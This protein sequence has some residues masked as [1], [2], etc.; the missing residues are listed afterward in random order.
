MKKILAL[1]VLLMFFWTLGAQPIDNKIIKDQIATFKKEPKG[2]YQQIMWYCPDGS[3]VPPKQRCPEK[4]GVQR[5]TYNSWIENLAKSNHIYLGQILSATDFAEFLDEENLYSRM[6]QYQIEN[7]LKNV[8]NG[9]VVR[10]AIYYRG[11]FQDEDENSWGLRFLNWTLTEKDL[12]Q[13][14]FFLMRQAFVSIPHKAENSNI[15]KVRALSKELSDSIPKFMDLRI[16]IHGQ[17]DAGDIKQ[18][19]AFKT[20]NTLTIQPEMASKFDELLREMEILYQAVDWQSLNSFMKP[21]GASSNS[22]KLLQLALSELAQSKSISEKMTIAARLMLN[23]REIIP[24]ENV[25]TKMAL[26]DLSVRTE[27]LIFK[28]LPNWKVST[29]A[30]LI[31]RN[32]ILSMVS[33]GAGY[34]ELWEWKALEKELLPVSD[35]EITLAALTN[36]LVAARRSVEWSTSMIKTNYNDEVLLFEGFEPLASAFVDDRIRSTVLLP[37]G[38]SVGDLGNFINK[39]SSLTNKV[40]NI[41]N[42]SHMRGVNPGFAKGELVVLES[43]EGIE[44]SPQKIYVFQQPPADLKPIAGIATVSEGNL[45]SHVQLLARNLGIPNAVVSKENL[46]ALKAFAGKEVFYAVSNKGTVILKLATDMTTEEKELV[47]V[48]K[49]TQEKIKVPIDRMDLKK[50][51]VLNLREVNATS[52]GKICGPKAANLGQLKAMFPKNVVE[53]LVIPFGIFRQHMDQ[54]MPN[55]AQSYWEFLNAA[56]AEASR[57]EKNGE[58]KSSCDAYLL[59]KLEVLRNAIQVMPLLPSFINDFKNQ[60]QLIL[61]KSVG[62][63]PVFVRS[64]TNMEDLKDFTGA[65]LNLTLFNIVEEEKIF[66]GIKKVW[67]SPYTERSFQWRQSYL[68]NPENVYPSILVIPSVNVDC[69]GVMIT[70]G[71]SMGGNDDL[72]IAFSRG[73][74]GAVDGQMAESYLLKSNN[75]DLL[76]APARELYFNELPLSGGTNKHATSFEKPILNN[77]NL[78]AIRDFSLLLKQKME[79]TKSMQGPFDVEMGFLNNQLWLFQVRPFNENKKATGALYLESITPKVDESKRISLTEKL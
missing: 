8:D 9:W 34:L 21:L 39:K 31:Q 7:Y 20:K 38:Q 55:S 2:P 79:E 66:Q 10:R 16:K 52:S 50:Q 68:L 76:L 33:A 14:N 1:F 73:V 49:R 47:S 32:Y 35:N 11:A 3:K 53:G 28:D 43:A 75:N 23:V 41:P 78:K 56:F 59:K 57:M 65:G 29:P 12:S 5:A 44:A 74:G 58:T 48:K 19:Q 25:K 45:V 13:R 26:Y 51:N 6:K 70:K 72:T 22:G 18:V 64:D 40:F 71:V 61:G 42:Q 24:A 46:M 37:L 60:F 62:E 27:E 69:S 17:P 67:A 30:E 15:Q 36:Y 77:L 63:I 4:G 54:K